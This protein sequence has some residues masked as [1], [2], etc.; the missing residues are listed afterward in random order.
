MKIQ[1][2]K[3][4]HRGE[5][6]EK[7]MKSAR[8]LYVIQAGS[9]HLIGIEPGT[10]VTVG[11]MEGK[12]YTAPIERIHKA[13]ASWHAKANPSGKTR[14]GRLLTSSDQLQKIGK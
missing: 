9:S 2:T 11:L 12:R 7:A 13:L 4:A 6:E 3:T 8:R 5:E 1:T 14:R 10:T